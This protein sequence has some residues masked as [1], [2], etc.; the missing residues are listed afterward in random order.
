[1]LED[2]GIIP[3]RSIRERKPSLKSVVYLVI[4]A[5]R[6]KHLKDKWAGQV[7]VKQKFVTS[8]LQMKK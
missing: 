6:M 2:M 5:L 3:D 8:A 7:K 4:A 1:M